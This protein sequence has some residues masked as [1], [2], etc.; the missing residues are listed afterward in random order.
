MESEESQGEVNVLSLLSE[1]ANWT[2]QERLQKLPETLQIVNNF[3]EM[4]PPAKK[5]V[6]VTRFVF[7]SFLPHLPVDKTAFCLFNV[8]LPC[9][10]SAFDD[11]LQ[12]CGGE[13]E[14]NMDR[15]IELL[16]KCSLVTEC[17]ELAV[18]FLLQAEGVAVENVSSL[19]VVLLHI[20]NH[21]FDHCK[22]SGDIYG[23][24]L[25]HVKESLSALFHHAVDLSTQFTTLL[26]KLTFNSFCDDDLEVL[27]QVCEQLCVTATSLSQLS[28]IRCCVVVWRAY[29]S[30]VQHHHGELV[31][32]IDISVP[33][34]PLVKEIK[35]GLD[36]IASIPVK[37]VT[38]AEKDQKVVQ[39]I[40]KMTS[41]CLKVIIALCEK[42]RGY[43]RGS[44]SL[45]VSLLLLL[46][47]FSPN[48]VT[49]QLYPDSIK[50]DI[51]RQATIGIEPLLIHLRRDEEFIKMMFKMDQ[52]GTEILAED[53]GNYL[54]LLLAVCVPPSTISALYNNTFIT[55]IFMVVKKCHASF[56]FP[57]VMDGVMYGGR[58]RYKVAL[59]E[60]LLIRMCTLVATLEIQNFE[61]L[62]QV[63]VQWLLSGQTWPA[64][65]AAD[66]W[67]FV[68]RFGTSELCKNH[69]TV[70]MDVL[71]QTPPSSH[72][73]LM[74]ASLLSRLLPKLTSH[75]RQEIISNFKDTG[76]NVITRF[77]IL[78][79]GNEDGTPETNLIND[80]VNTC[81][82]K[83]NL[84]LARSASEQTVMKVILSVCKE[85]CTKGS[86]IVGVA[87]CDLVEALGHCHFTQSL[88]HSSILSLI[89]DVIS[90]VLKSSNPL[91]QQCAL[92]AFVA[93]GQHTI[94]EEVLP[95]CLTYCEKELQDQV[96]NYLQQEPHVLPSGQSR[97]SLFQQQN[98]TILDIQLQ[99]DLKLIEDITTPE[100]PQMHMKESLSQD[101]PNQEQKP[102]KRLRE[103]EDLPQEETPE[104]KI[105]LES[106][107]CSCNMMKTINV[108]IEERDTVRAILQEMMNIW[109]MV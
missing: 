64:L 28:E 76:D 13:A 97:M 102:T 32:R 75:H 94:H 83:M 20:I 46:F 88:E 7:G 104:L 63:L 22:D 95:M 74:T 47:R 107:H 80:V 2:D 44:H 90:Q 71:P 68:A 61:A 81:T 34:T 109:E 33:L 43:L 59:Y 5:R 42:F 49:L 67:S 101:L 41:F 25:E 12:V 10:K 29:T 9:L 40:I 58:P 72:Q 106:L 15:T 21:T 56:S 78:Q 23:S 86:P 38:M 6:Q 108:T 93:F 100:F 17:C 50:N 4:T 26:S 11:F 65:L 82:E 37:N 14:K 8:A 89:S 16:Q 62:E 91:V 53:W 36:L 96:T 99:K 77:I 3:L 70:L 92:D 52:D 55:K 54:L 69:C 35:D 48:N 57:C 87:L 98:I 84:F 39:R 66:L 19:P 85:C 60:H 31:T 1:A 79:A 51:E 30:L 73:R 27:L 24:H 45:L 105:L 18:Q 103:D